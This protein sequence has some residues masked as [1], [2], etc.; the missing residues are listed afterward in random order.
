MGHAGRKQRYSPSFLTFAD[1]LGSK[2]GVPLRSH[3]VWCYPNPGGHPQLGS[4]G[5]MIF[6]VFLSFGIWLSDWVNPLLNTMS[7]L[8][9]YWQILQSCRIELHEDGNE[10]L[11]TRPLPRITYLDSE[12]ELCTSSLHF[13]G[14]SLA[15]GFLTNFWTS[16]V[17]IKR[18]WGRW[19][20][21]IQT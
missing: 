11:L 15:H 20:F 3:G 17:L 2:E 12:S 5:I 10:L 18:H 16:E 19:D 8:F 21:A 6:G 1:S 9:V 7:N 14:T 4:Y 13:L